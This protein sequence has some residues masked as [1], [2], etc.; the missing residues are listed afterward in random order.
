VSLVNVGIS[1]RLTRRSQREQW[2]RND[3]RPIVARCLTLS[4]DGLREWEKAS[5]A[6]EAANPGPDPDPYRSW[7]EHPKWEKG[8]KLIED[9]RYEVAQ[10]DLLAGSAVR[11]VANGLLEAHLEEVARLLRAEPGRDEVE[12]RRA[13]TRILELQWALVDA[14]REDLGLSLGLG[15]AV[16]PGSLLGRLLASRSGQ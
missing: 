2:R 9:L 1:A 12:A 11:Q 3:E 4:G 15:L 16:P 10:L 6:K 13:R 14:A 8:R 7:Q 5:G